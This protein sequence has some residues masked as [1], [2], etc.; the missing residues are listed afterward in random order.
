MKIKHIIILLLLVHQSVKAQMADSVRLHIDSSLL[1]LKE[2]SLYA[3]SLNWQ[4]IKGKVFE[5]AKNAITKGETFEALKIAFNALGDKH[6]AYYQDSYSYKLD[7][8]ELMARYSDSIKVAWKE[9]PKIDGRMINDIAYFAVP[10]M[11][12]NKQE[13]IDSYANWLYDEVAKLQHQNP[14]GWIIDLRLNG[15]GNSVQC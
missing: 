2:N 11:G 1:I 4:E 15:G 5:R 13:Q 6:A 10:F 3:N 12:V 14:K 9:G 7:N 8:A